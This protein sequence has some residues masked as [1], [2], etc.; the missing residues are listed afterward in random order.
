VTFFSSNATTPS[1]DEQDFL[2]Y[3]RSSGGV[4][5]SPEIDVSSTSKSVV[6]ETCENDE[7][8][9]LKKDS[10]RRTTLSRVLTQDEQKICQVWMEKIEHDRPETFVLRIVSVHLIETRNDKIIKLFVLHSRLTWNTSVELSKST[11]SS[12][13]RKLSSEHSIT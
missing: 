12:R 10:Q 11:S 9:L 1:V 8:F 2:I 13:R 7:F 4:L 6:G 5:L 3:R